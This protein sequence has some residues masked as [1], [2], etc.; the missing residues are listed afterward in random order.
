MSLSAE[1]MKTAPSSPL[2]M[3]EAQFRLFAAEYLAGAATHDQL[4]TIEID[5]PNRLSAQEQR[6]LVAWIRANNFVVYAYDHGAWP[7]GYQRICAQLGLIDPVANPGADSSKVT[8]IRDLGRDGTS[9]QHTSPQHRRYIPYSNSALGWHTDGYYN[10]PKD[11]IRAF[12]LHCGFP[13]ATGGVN[14]W[15][16]PLILYIQLRQMNPEWAAALA[17]PD[18]FTIPENTIE[19]RII[20]P[21]FSGS[22]FSTGE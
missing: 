21:V 10:A 7:C 16:D 15:I 14:Q 8:T 4:K 2:E 9:A 5:N 20:R 19:N 12:V 6:A 1:D 3:D 13:A 18:V 11:I 17:R 22:V